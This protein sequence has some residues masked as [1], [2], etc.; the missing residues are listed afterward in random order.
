VESEPQDP[1]ETRRAEPDPDE[2]LVRE[3][4]D[5]AAAEAGAIGGRR[6]P[7]DEHAEAMR[8]L[9]EAGEGE[10]EG[11]E[12]AERELVEHASHGDQAPD[13]SR[14]A[15]EENEEGLEATIEYS[16]ADH[17]ESSEREGLDEQ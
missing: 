14:F 7:G 2:Q 16:D 10:A 11:F 13:P 8:P 5:A 9:E 17:F 12:E 4:E 15:E 3:Q 1:I 6:A